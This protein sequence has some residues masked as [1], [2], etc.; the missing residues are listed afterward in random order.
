[1]EIE[2]GVT[3]SSNARACCPWAGAPLRMV[4]NGS[5]RSRSLDTVDDAAVASQFRSA[6]EQAR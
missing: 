6:L 5:V 2:I 3:A 1:M 4:R